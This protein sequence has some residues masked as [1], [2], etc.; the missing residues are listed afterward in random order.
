MVAFI[1]AENGQLIVY[2]LN[3][4]AEQVVDRNVTAFALD[5]ANIAYVNNE[6]KVFY[7]K[8]GATGPQATSY[9]I[10]KTTQNVYHLVAVMKHALILSGF[11]KVGGQVSRFITLVDKRFM[12]QITEYVETSTTGRL[13]PYKQKLTTLL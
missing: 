11:A 3:K 12:T 10:Q 8:I 1:A 9:Q 6:N 5:G 4:R 13:F 7:Q 2:D